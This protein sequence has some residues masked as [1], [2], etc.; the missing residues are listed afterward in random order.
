MRF[1]DEGVVVCGR[2]G[3]KCLEGSRGT[4]H[5]LKVKSMNGGGAERK[6]MVDRLMV[7]GPDFL[8]LRATG[9]YQ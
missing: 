8:K 9:F 5:D 4:H 1:Q 3:G 6:R 7:L 2:E